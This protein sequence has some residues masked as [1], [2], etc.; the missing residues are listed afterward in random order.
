MPKD[1]NLIAY[2][3]LAFFFIVFLL[4]VFKGIAT[5]QPGDENVYYYMGKLIAEGKIPYR[6]FLYA[7]PPLQIYLIALI[8]KIFGFNVVALKLVPLIST[9]ISAFFVFRIAKEKFGNAEALISAALFLFGYSIMFNSAFSFGIEIAAMLLIVGFYF[10]WNKSNYALSG[11]FLGLASI[12]R[13]LSLIPIAVILFFVFFSNKKDFIKLSSVFFAV[14]LLVNG[15][16]S[17]SFGNDYL[18]PVYKYHFL[19]SFGYKENF[20]E[21]F[22]I[23]KLNWVLFASSLL[24]VFAKDKKK[25]S[26]PVFISAVY[27]FF[28]IFLNKLFG[29]YF[30][31]TFPFL[32][33]I[34][35]YSIAAIFETINLAKKWKIP[36]GVILFLIFLWNLSSDVMFLQKIGFLGFERGNDL[37]DFVNLNSNKST[38]LFGDDSVVPLLA[39]MANKKIAL[40]F[41][42]TNNQIFIA[43]VRDLDNILNDLKGKD[44][45]FVIRSRQ[46]ISAFESVR[47]F[48]SRNCEFLSAFHDKIEG[49]YLVY[50]CK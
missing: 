33:L 50:R 15:I 25:L 10:L 14:F 29:F 45:L 24:F 30:I 34:G 37:V 22:D 42:D 16:F 43:G 44:I 41:V 46:G 20:R 13:L 48:L 28:L 8:Y 18:V 19:K 6:D 11:L 47:N 7:H 39:L 49:D 26:M 31:M 36:A 38:L 40:D 2:L 21:Y 9:L 23:I 32:A 3:S 35:G 12:T 27:L 1:K 5:A 17:F 4:I